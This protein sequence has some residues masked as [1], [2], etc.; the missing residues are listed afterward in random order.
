MI[1]LQNISVGCH[2]GN[3]GPNLDVALQPIRYTHVNYTGRQQHT[4]TKV[5]V[6]QLQE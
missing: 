1:E 4:G 6:L 5:V 3:F 2:P